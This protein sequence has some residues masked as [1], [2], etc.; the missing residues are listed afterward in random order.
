MERS[1]IEVRL[2][3]VFSALILLGLMLLAHLPARAQG[4]TTSYVYDENGRLRVVIS[5]TGEAVAYEYDPAGNPT[6]V[7][8]YTAN[9]FVILDFSP[10]SGAA[11]DP[12]RIVGVGFVPTSN[13]V[14]FNGVSATI[15]SWSPN[16]IVAK[17]PD[18]AMTGPIKVIKS[19]GAFAQSASNFVIAPRLDVTPDNVTLTPDS[20]LQFT[21][22][23]RSI[24]GG[25]NVTWSANGIAG[26]DSDAGTIT[27]TGLYRAPAAGSAQV[28]IRATSTT[29]PEFFGEAR[30]RVSESATVTAA[31]QVSV[32]YGAEA[33]R[34]NA[35]V[36]SIKGT[37]VD[38]IAPTSIQ[39][40]SSQ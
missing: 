34:F 40:G 21:A 10:K 5:T 27:S 31:A 4:G 25:T 2:K 18:S 38:G 14:Q 8:R 11:D 1:L 26:G 35:L 32:K 6:A 30:V 22:V 28:T 37:Y 24:P 13:S 36:S 20:L 23:P 39:R 7:R 33:G 15:V 3:S 29:Q 9:D 16:E 12:V 19:G 17:V